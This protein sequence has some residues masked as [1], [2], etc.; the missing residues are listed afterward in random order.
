MIVFPIRK[1]IFPSRFSGRDTDSDSPTF[2]RIAST[3]RLTEN[4]G[5][6]GKAILAIIGRLGV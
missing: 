2:W 3:R 5:L 4:F 6:A 1:V